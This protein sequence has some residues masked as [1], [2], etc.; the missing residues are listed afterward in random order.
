MDSELNPKEER[1]AVVRLV[2]YVFGLMLVGS[3][4]LAINTGM[5][6]GLTQGINQI[7][8]ERIG[9]SQLVQFSIYL[10][11]VALLCLEWYLWDLVTTR[12]L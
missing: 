4:L 9:V 2:V 8:P 12:K 11:P 7:L 1:R 10:G 3:L 5:V 6:F